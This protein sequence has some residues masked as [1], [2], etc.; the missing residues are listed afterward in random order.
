MLYKDVEAR[1]K[2]GN[3]LLFSRESACLQE[4]IEGLGKQNHRTVILWAL[5][6]A[7]IPLAEIETEY[8][9]EQRPRRCLQI[10]A[11][12]AQGKVKMPEAK[13][14]ILACHAV[15]KTIDDPAM[16]ALCH[17]I[18]QAAASVHTETHALGLA[19]YELTAL[20]IRS[21]DIDW[22][23]PVSE[24]LAYYTQRLSYWAENTDKETREWASF[25]SDDSLFKKEA[26]L[27]KKRKPINRL[28]ES[29]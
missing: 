15:A 19:I 13:K 14:A 8:P 25:L 29:Q 5:D 18:G 17:A 10:G 27:S 11:Q 3:Q 22:I 23:N 7:Q 12:W 2:K 24:K 9:F 20:V 28:S 4:L 6:C 16:I 26:L 21:K 1:I